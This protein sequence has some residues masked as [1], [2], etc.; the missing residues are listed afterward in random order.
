MRSPHRYVIQPNPDYV[1]TVERE[2]P[3]CTIAVV[4]A[5]LVARRWYLYFLHNQRGQLLSALLLRGA[6]RMAIINV[7]W[8]LKG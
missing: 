5:E 1:L 7:P 2:N 3:D 8:R 6:H 4:I